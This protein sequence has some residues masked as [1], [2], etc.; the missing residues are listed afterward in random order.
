M[1]AA[2]VTSR[3]GPSMPARVEQRLGVDSVLV[4]GD[5]LAFEQDRIARHAP[6]YEQIGGRIRGLLYGGA[7]CVGSAGRDDDGRLPGAVEA[8]RV[9]DPVGRFIEVC[10]VAG[11]R[12]RRDRVTE[13][14]DR[15]RALRLLGRHRRVAS[16]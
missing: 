16:R 8:R 9:H 3:I 7:A 1:C 5:A 11:R 4:G 15:T 14:Y 2:L 10:P 13:Q 12:P 6:L